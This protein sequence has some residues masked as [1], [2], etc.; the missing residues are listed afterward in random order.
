MA[1]EHV[2]VLW[3]EALD[4]LDIRPDG[5]YVDCTLGAGGHSLGILEKLQTGHLY[6][7]D[8]DKQAIDIAKKRL[9]KFSEQLTIIQKNFTHF[10]QALNEYN[11]EKVS[12][13]LFDIGVSS[14]QFDQDIRGFSYRFDAPLDM[15]MNQEQDLSAYDI[16]NTY[17]KNE[18]LSILFNYGEEKFA[19][20]IVANIIKFREQKPIKTTFELVD[21]IKASV[22]QKYQRLKHP[23]KKTF[24][25]L[26][27]AVNDELQVFENALRQAIERTMK[28]G[29]IVVITFHSIEDR[30]CKKVF[31]EFGKR[32]GPQ[33]DIEKLLLVEEPLKLKILTRQP[34]LASQ[35]EIKTN[36]RAKSAKL[37]AV[38][39]K[40]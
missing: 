23:A 28:G 1:L 11:V 8:Q 5:V 6:A 39:I 37:R 15:R 30:I 7:F 2:S 13:V 33:N 22:P 17:E 10:N 40:E 31:Q 18:L 29:R 9:S 25:A 20:S 19:H 35:E 12:G 36:P 27:I 26:R 16:V 3:K 21:I 32:K 34:I 4:F 38:E 24:Q 14:M